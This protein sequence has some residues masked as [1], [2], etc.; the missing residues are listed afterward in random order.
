[1][2]SKG[3]AATVEI[4][5]K[6]VQADKSKSDNPPQNVEVAD[7]LEEAVEKEETKLRDDERKEEAKG[8]EAKAEVAAEVADTA[9]KLDK[10]AATA[11]ATGD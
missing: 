8:D 6:I 3:P 9:Q 10:D 2:V 1:M 11:D 4:V 5:R 7:K